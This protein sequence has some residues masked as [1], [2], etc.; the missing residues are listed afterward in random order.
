MKFSRTPC[1]IE[2]VSPDVG[3]HSME[4]FNDMLGISIKEIEDLRKN[5]VI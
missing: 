2:K 4:V 3:Q 5:K 1:K